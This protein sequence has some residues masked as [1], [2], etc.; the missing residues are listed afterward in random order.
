MTTSEIE[1]RQ[2]ILGAAER[3]FCHYGSGKTTIGDIAKEVG[4]GVGS[5]YL[6]FDSKDDIVTELTRQRH[7]D[8]LEAMRQAAR[9]GTFAER[10]TRMMVA[11][12]QALF[13]FSELGTHACELIQ[14]DGQA[15]KHWGATTSDEEVTLLA[16]LIERGGRES[17]FAMHNPRAIAE[18]ILRAFA[19]LTPP[20]IFQL[21]ER[22]ALRAVQELAGLLLNGIVARPR[23][24]AT[25]A[26]SSPRRQRFGSR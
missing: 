24:S 17:E 23:T 5:V 10:L 26:A 8:V 7:R 25:A 13:K 18:L 21:S 20:F 16:A 19:T 15:P 9:E 4:I 12:T 2:A 11:R 3:L 1:R 6:E 14:C 22:E